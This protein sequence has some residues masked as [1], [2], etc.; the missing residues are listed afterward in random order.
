MGLFN[1]AQAR[2]NSSLVNRARQGEFVPAAGIDEALRRARQKQNEAALAQAR[3]ELPT[4]MSG[5]PAS[6]KAKPRT[7]V[8]AFFREQLKTFGMNV[9]AGVEKCA[10]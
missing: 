10:L 4:G 1:T 9:L 6:P 8:P 3:N 5:S 7:G 2:R